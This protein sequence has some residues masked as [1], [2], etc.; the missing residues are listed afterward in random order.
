MTRELK[1]IT[2]TYLDGSVE[3]YPKKD[4]ELLNKLSD[5]CGIESV[6]QLITVMALSFDVDSTVA[7]IR[8]DHQ[9]EL[10]ALKT[11]HRKEKEEYKKKGIIASKSK[12]DG[13]MLEEWGLYLPNFHYNPQD[14]R[15]M[16]DPSDSIIYN[17][18]T[19]F[20][21]VREIILLDWQL[22]SPYASTKTKHQIKDC[23]ER[24]DVRFEIGNAPLGR[25]EE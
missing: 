15:L 9:E 21:E 14:L 18:L 13:K 4:L 8:E 23:I 19:E 2:L 12:L 7:S 1:G 22:K 10:E 11:A 17:G 6:A 25:Q 20:G 3:E 16:R 5:S 24:K